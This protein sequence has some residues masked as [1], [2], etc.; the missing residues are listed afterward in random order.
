MKVLHVSSA[1]SWRGGENQIHLLISGLNDL[2]IQNHLMS[3]RAS[4]LLK[5]I[6]ASLASKH[7]YVKRSGLSLTSALCLKRIVSKN[8]IDIV[9][10][11]DSHSH[12]YAISASYL[13]MNRPI[14]VTRRV[15]FGIGKLSRFKYNH[16]RIHSIVA[17][18]EA[19]KKIM[20]YS[21]VT[22]DI[23]TIYSGVD[24]S[25]KITCEEKRSK[26][27]KVIGF[28]GAMV[29]HK[30]PITFVK[31]AHFLNEKNDEYSFLMAGVEGELKTDVLHEIEKYKLNDCIKVV[32]FVE[33]KNKIWEYIDILVVPSSEEG[34]GT[35][36]LEA[37]SLGIPVVSTTA[38]GLP[39][40]V[41][42][43]YT[44]LTSPVR[45]IDSLVKNIE[46][47]FSDIKLSTKLKADAKKFVK[48]FDFKTMAN[49]Y[50]EEYNRITSN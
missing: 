12:N 44:G 33:N 6:D 17:V 16:R 5:R 7:S 47:I 10:V 32:G 38:G 21:G 40:I 24:L 50:L 19:V 49:K 26:R 36:V 8:D 46:R 27:K 2:G 3:P 11:H 34:L 30:D 23:K 15:D 48:R 20:R 45:D 41:I 9:H 14:I 25:I 37:F 35:V 31:L 28:V 29:A 22:S 1:I 18:S 42:H 39:E 13:G 43:E 4:H